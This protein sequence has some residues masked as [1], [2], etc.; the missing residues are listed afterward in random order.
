MASKPAATGAA[1]KKERGGL[2][3]EV[4]QESETGEAIEPDLDVEFEEEAFD[5]PGLTESSPKATQSGRKKDKKSTGTDSVTEEQAIASA[6]LQLQI[7]S[8]SKFI[9][10]FNPKISERV[11]RKKKTVRHSRSTGRTR[12]QNQQ[13]VYG[14]DGTLVNSDKDLCDCL[15]SDCPGCYYPCPKCGSGKCGS[16]CRVNRKWYYEKVEVEGTK[17]IWKNEFVKKK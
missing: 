2:R 4:C 1:S 10:N 15:Q 7:C 8:R 17:L 5:D 11:L 9:Q 3:H 6:L 16:E 12:S 14:P 13:C